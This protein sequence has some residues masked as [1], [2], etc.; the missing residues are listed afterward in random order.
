MYEDLT[1]SP[2]IQIISLCFLSTLVSSEKHHSAEETSCSVIQIPFDSDTGFLS[3]LNAKKTFLL[4]TLTSRQFSLN[5][6][7]AL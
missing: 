2:T 6:V 5:K 3:W 1:I 4:R 7:F